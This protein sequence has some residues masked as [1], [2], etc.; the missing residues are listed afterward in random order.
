MDDT[1][2][3]PSAQYSD[4]NSLAGW[5]GAGDLSKL[6][7][8]GQGWQTVEN[9]QAGSDASMQ[10][11]VIDPKFQDW[12]NQ[13]NYSLNTTAGYGFGG[14]GVYDKNNNLLAQKAWN[15]DNEFGALVN[16]GVAAV[17][18]GALGGGGLAG[19]LGMNPGWAAGALNGAATGATIAGGNQQDALQ[20]ALTG[21][22]GGGISGFNPAGQMGIENTALKAGINSATGSTLAQLAAGKDLSTAAKTGATSGLFSAG[23]NAMNDFFSG[24]WNQYSGDNSAGYSASPEINASYPTSW[25]DNGSDALRK[26]GIDSYQKSFVPPSS[27]AYQGG[28]TDF[29]ADLPSLSANPATNASYSSGY[30]PPGVGVLE[31]AGLRPEASY[32]PP[33]SPVQGDASQALFNSVVPNT[34]QESTKSASSF[35]L[36]NA[37][38]LG[39]FAGSN[40]GALAQMLYGIYNNR[41]QQGA[42]QAQMAGLQGLYGQ[43]SPY[44]TQLRAKLQAQAAAQGKRTNTDARETQ[45]QAMLA[46]RAASLAPSLYQMQQGQMGLQNSLFSNL[47]NQGS[48]LKGLGALFGLGG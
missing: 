34:T 15:P 26:A 21:G 23:N 29:L 1:G 38:Q 41:R 22:V 39:S 47:I 48:N 13:N 46:D 20:G 10:S 24:L 45:L 31:Q 33:G 9:G 19:S 35:S 7:Y 32:A 36:P 11:N 40:A 12:L 4:W 16:A 43:N 18:G 28:N 30:K 42:L 17:T 37:S 8:T 44:A 27:L 14:A 5:F 3:D 25:A 2:I 6:G